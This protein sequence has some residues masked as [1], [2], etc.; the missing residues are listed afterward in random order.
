MKVMDPMKVV[1][2]QAISKSL[3]KMAALVRAKSSHGVLLELR[4]D[5]PAGS[6]IG[7]AMV[8]ANGE[9]QT[10]MMPF[11]ASTDG[12]H[13]LYVSNMQPFSLQVHLKSEY[14]R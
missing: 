12:I 7:S 11:H 10:I 1:V 3:G 6:T 5:D 9:W 13:K 4:I 8:V 14:G 2:G